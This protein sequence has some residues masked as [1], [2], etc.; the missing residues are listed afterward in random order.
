MSIVT[1]EQ[2]EDQLVVDSR[3]VAEELGIDHKVL[4]RNIRNHQQTIESAF[5][6]LSF[7]TATV[8]NSVGAVNSVTFVYLTEEQATFVMTLSRNTPQ[9][10]QCKVNLVQAFSEAKKK[11]NQPQTYLEALKALVE[12]EE[13][14]E[15]LR[16]ERESLEEENQVLSETVDELFDY[17]SIIRVAK[18]NKVSEKNFS[19]RVLK[20]T[21]QKME[22]EIKKVPD[23]RFG[24]KNL[25]PH[26]AWRYA[27]PDVNL[28]ETTTLRINR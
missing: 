8:T 21:S 14:K 26:D 20:K 23:P 1:V 18:Y 5:G 3:L 9:V 11:L 15:R 6:Q 16:L 4:I 24:S 17:S 12:S 27:Y 10:I 13:E 25:Y 22:L 28:P 7:D 19:W 2:K